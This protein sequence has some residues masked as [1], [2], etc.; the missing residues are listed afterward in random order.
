MADSVALNYPAAFDTG[1]SDTSSVPNQYYAWLTSGTTPTD[2]TG[3]LYTITGTDSGTSSTASSGSV[4]SWLNSNATT[5]LVA[6]GVFLAVMMFTRG[7]R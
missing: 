1:S 2:P 4:T 6:A 7:R 5:V 3:G